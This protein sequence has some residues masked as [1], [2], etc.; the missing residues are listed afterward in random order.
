MSADD[1]RV[2][3][4]GFLR[5]SI[6]DDPTAWTGWALGARGAQLV[7]AALRRCRP[8][9][10]LE[11]GSGASTVVLAEY[12]KGRRRNLRIISLESDARFFKETN[13]RLVARN[14]RSRVD[15]RLVPLRGYV[16]PFGLAQW[17]ETEHLPYGIDFALIDGPPGHLSNGRLATLPALW[18]RLALDCEL[19]LDDAH[20][21]R[22]RR[23]LHQWEQRY[24][25]SVS[26]HEAGKKLMAKVTR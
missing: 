18:D 9:Y 21:L 8:S 2:D 22:E 26:I 6:I 23:A 7:D 3:S 24:G 4:A 25:I 10:I 5:D 19:W 14:L 12:A 13:D 16:T 17:Y 20:R 1:P 11:A 15:L